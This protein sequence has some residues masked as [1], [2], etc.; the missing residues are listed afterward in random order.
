[1]LTLMNGTYVEENMMSRFYVQIYN[2]KIT[3]M[4][5]QNPNYKIQRVK[6]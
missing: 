4:G 5:V 3:N 2:L 6:I 1:M